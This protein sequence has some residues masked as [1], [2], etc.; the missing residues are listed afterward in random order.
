MILAPLSAA[1]RF[2]SLH[3]L[4]PQAFAYLKNFDPQTPDGK[5]EIVGKN[6]YA[7]VQR[8]AT[9]PVTEKKWEAHEIYGDIQVVYAGQEYCGHLER[10]WL[11]SIQPY[12]AEKDVEKFAAPNRPYS[13][14]LL[15][16]GQF[17]IFYPEDGHQPGVSIAESIEVL[18][19]VIKFR[20]Q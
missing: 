4:F 10:R 15:S 3:P 6:L 19:V 9:S 2:T 7:G 11:Q 17:C 12:S 13:Q 5:Y 20:L 8:Y 14:L 18:K 1:H 16:P